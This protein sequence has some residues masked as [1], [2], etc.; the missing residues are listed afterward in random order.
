MV[1]NVALIAMLFFWLALLGNLIYRN[2]VNPITVFCGTWS[3]IIL[4]YSFR[5]FDLYEASM[6]SLLLIG[7]GVIMFFIGAIVATVMK[8]KHKSIRINPSI[9]E[10]TP[11]PNYI[12]LLILNAISFIFLI[13]FGITTIRML[14][15]GHNFYYIHS[16]YYEDAGTVGA[17][18]T[19]QNIFSWYV[20]PLMDASI[21]TFAVVIQADKKKNKY[22][23][24]SL[25]IVIANLFLF[26]VITA[27]RSHLGYIVAYIIATYIMQ[28]RRAKLKKRTKLAI[29]A[30][31]LVIIWAFDAI[32]TSRGSES[33]IRTLYIYFT[34]C[35]PHLSIKLSDFSFQPKGIASIYGFYQAPLLILNSLF[36]FPFISKIFSSMSELVAVTQ[37]RVL[38]APGISFNAFLTPFYYFYLDGGMI[39]NILL[40]FIFGFVST[41]VYINHLNRRN[42]NSMINYLLVFFTL[43]M[44]MVRIQFFQM[45]FSLSFLYVYLL[46]KGNKVKFVVGKK[47]NS[48]AISK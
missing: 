19:Y 42:Y 31:V 43:Y 14:L 36:H 44:S 20:W 35:I 25:I 46:F 27:K 47:N 39:G 21:A 8:Y 4:A 33:L 29:I 3:L 38:I 30:G 15:S 6:E 45:R 7:V 34:G 24:I 23:N 5:A 11:T 26:T 32:S 12:F 18:K 22:K 28:G 13:G 40:S 41:L 9:I 1:V 17:S 16:L 2:I 37:R 10:D 48:M